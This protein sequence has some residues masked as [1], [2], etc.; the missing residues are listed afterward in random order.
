MAERIV[1]QQPEPDGEA[2]A[3]VVRERF[4]VLTHRHPPTLKELDELVRLQRLLCAHIVYIEQA[5]RA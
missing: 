2:V 1:P 4:L 5:G 3:D